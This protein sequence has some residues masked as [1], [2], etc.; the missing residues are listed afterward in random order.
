MDLIER[1]IR[2]SLVT[3]LAEARVV[4]L[5][6]ARQAGKTTLVRSVADQEHP[7]R[8]VSLDDPAALEVAR[9]DPAGFVAGGER[10]VIDEVQRAP[11]LLLAIKRVVDTD[12]A[13][14]Q[15]LLTGSANILTLP[16]IADALPGRVD[17]LTIW[18]FSQGEL[19]GTRSGFL[20]ASFAGKSPAVEAAQIGRLAYAE[21]IIRGGFP[22]IVDASWSRR[23]RFFS[24]YA[25]SILGR[26]VDELSSLRDSEASGR[27]LRLLTARSAA[28]TNFSSIGR[29]L[30]IDHKTVAAHIRALEQ[31][32]IVIRLPAWH[33]NL[34]H[35]VVRS[36]KLHVADTGML[37]SLLGVDAERLDEDSG[38]A[39][40]VF[41]TFVVSEIVRL[42]SV[43][44]LGPLLNLYHYRDQR[45]HE[46]DLVIEHANGEVVGIEVKASASPRLRD[47]AGL[48][49]LRDRLGDRFRQG[50]LLHLG[51][52]SL[53]LGERLSAVPLAGL[54]SE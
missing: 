18:P 36:A 6:G 16:Q 49:L 31:L 42:A 30:G 32:F 45:G 22:E 51:P 52:E 11:D 10:L 37:C 44:E 20:E 40:S 27:V 7:A 29:E 53:S 17:Y 48:T 15:F 9:T 33:A 38:L 21:Q 50:V 24:G 2:P 19:R 25:D 46:V 28:L 14:G 8:Y 47:A 3:A 43:S 54:W 4:C 26:E 39:G 1:H 34:G 13:R 12:S 35:R 23:R 41:E 5:L